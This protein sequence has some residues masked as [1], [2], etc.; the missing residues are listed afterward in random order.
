MDTKEYS[1]FRKICLAFLFVVSLFLVSNTL[2]NAIQ[3]TSHTVYAADKDDKDTKTTHV[4]DNDKGD[5]EDVQDENLKK[6]E[7][8]EKKKKAQQQKKD[9]KDEDEQKEKEGLNRSYASQIFDKTDENQSMLY[10]ASQ[11]PNGSPSV[12]TVINAAEHKDKVGKKGGLVG[13]GIDATLNAINGKKVDNIKGGE[14]L[15]YATFLKTLHDWN[16]YHTYTNQLDVGVGI[17]GKIIVLVYGSFLLGLVWLMGMLDQILIQF[18]HIIKKLNIFEYIA[19]DH[20][21][22]PKKSPLHGLQPLVDLF[23][24]FSGIAM[25]LLAIGFAVLMF[26]TIS[27]LGKA[28][29]NRGGYFLRGFWLKMAQAFAIIGLPFMLAGFLLSFANAII[30]GEQTSKGGYTYVKGSVASIPSRYIIDTAGW[31]GGSLKDPDTN[32][33][34]LNGGY[35][36]KRPTNGAG[37]PE[38]GAKSV[39]R[40]APNEDFVEGINDIAKSA[41]GGKKKSGQD[42]LNEW[43]SSSTITS[44][45]LDTMY[46]VSKTDKPHMWSMHDEKRLFQFKLAPESDKVKAFEGKDGVVSMDLNDASIRSASLVGNG[47]FGVFLNGLAM[48]V[49]IICTVYIAVVLIVSVF[50]SFYRSIIEMATNLAKAQF[51]SFQSMLAV[52]STCI[53]MVVVFFTALMLIGVYSTL[54]HSMV[55]TLGKD[56]NDALPNN[57][58]GQLKE[59][60]SC[61]I[62]V[63]FYIFGV[64]IVFKMRHAIVQGIQEFLTNI[65]R[66]SGLDISGKQSGKKAAAAKA[67]EGIADAND[68]GEGFTRGAALATGA[69]AYGTGM[70]AVDAMDDKDRSFGEKARDALQD[71]VDKFSQQGS[72]KLA[73][74]ANDKDNQNLT[75]RIAGKL[76]EGLD[77]MN[78]KLKNNKEGD[79]LE[80]QEDKTN[81]ASDKSSEADD[82]RDKR[83]QLQQRLQDAEKNGASKEDM[84][85][86][87]QDLDKAN[88]DLAKKEKVENEAIDDMVSSGA[89]EEM[90]QESAEQTK[91]DR[92]D[93]ENEVKDAKQALQDLED[94]KEWARQNG[95]TEDE[96][97]D[98]YDDKIDDAKSRLDNA[99]EKLGMVNDRGD[100]TIDS[101]TLNDQEND[102]LAANQA[103]RSAEKAYNEAQQTGALSDAENNNIKSVAS[104]FKDDLQ[105][106][107]DEM[108][109]QLEEE[110]DRLAAMNRVN[111]QGESFTKA[112]QQAQA[113]N[114]NDAVK[115]LSAKENKLSNLKAN[116]APQSDIKRAQDAVNKAKNNVANEK[117]IQQAM[118][119]PSF[120]K[121]DHTNHAGHV[122]S[123]QNDHDNALN[124]ANRLK[125]QQAN[126]GHVSDAQIEQAENNASQIGASLATAQAITK[127]MKSS[128]GKITP[129]V[130]QQQQQHVD[131]LGSQLQSQQQQLQTLQNA[132]ANGGQVS[133]VSIDNLKDNIASTS[134]QLQTSKNALNNMSNQRAN[135]GKVT[136]QA[137]SSSGH[138][139]KRLEQA[140]DKAQ[141][142]Y[143]ALVQQENS[144]V[145]VSPTSMAKAKQDVQDKSQALQQ[146]VSI[147]KGLNA[148]RMTGGHV[149]KD[150]LQNQQGKVKQLK[151]RSHQLSQGISNMS[152]IQNG[153]K[154]NKSAMTSMSHASNLVR[155]GA[156]SRQQQAKQQ[157][158]AKEKAHNKLL[159]AAKRPGSR[160]SKRQVQASQ[161]ALNQRKQDL[162]H[163]NQYAQG[164]AGNVQTVYETGHQMNNNIKQARQRLSEASANKSRQHSELQR[165]RAVG[166]VKGSTLQRL[167]QDIGGQRQVYEQDKKERQ[168]IY[169]ENKQKVMQKAQLKSNANN[170]MRRGRMKTGT[171]NE[172]WR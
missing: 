91:Q 84:D 136:S 73:N 168:A 92:Q 145:H 99:E 144:G 24:H 109:P 153:S 104:G 19:P 90:A 18:A 129:A 119:T 41:N 100:G 20:G 113:N 63:F 17:V 78:D 123:L 21:Q 164:V 135:A 36:L 139:V 124:H 34:I 125:Q 1:I 40:G 127:G 76:S 65:M 130:Q 28:R 110:N 70:S 156:Q 172:Y 72:G 38:K 58:S 39:E 140:H 133:Q 152:D 22:I 11:A 155:E 29:T 62:T 57:S 67:L 15:K 115:D 150:A 64:V 30:D 87:Q 93:A 51:G 85:E 66:K 45:D 23:H 83:D 160:I 49:E 10:F 98:T 96:L 121:A 47:G 120:T 52:L 55:A 102:T 114:V 165:L 79:L 6:A 35:V 167:K 149:T 103:E 170:R 27:G 162:T 163:A 111:E 44:K 33:G 118:D 48:G 82:S 9:Q 5:G 101:E 112:D 68:D 97:A 77:N 154:V 143:Q 32:G 7:K 157:Y 108:A 25:I 142:D 80:E 2:I 61:L 94:E 43:R 134:S 13:K 3:P 95:A 59:L 37:F 117:A 107:S 14:G 116:H 86:I 161:Q 81:R 105:R 75:G 138:H 128:G 106:Q 148:Q 8:K 131:Q 71:G 171:S 122:Q 151:A 159:R 46:H 31:I 126:G 158:E 137:L 89:A 69:G 132:K 50:T 56:I 88:K 4:K 26:I 141:K 54:T 166:G 16:L 74:Y 147:Q 42:L 12:E 169:K 53:M 60:I 146:A